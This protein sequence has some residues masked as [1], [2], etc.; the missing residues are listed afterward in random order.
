M[1]WF[2]GRGGREIRVRLVWCVGRIVVDAFHGRSCCR[3]CSYC[4]RCLMWNMKIW[5]Y[6]LFPYE[7]IAQKVKPLWLMWGTF[8]DIFNE[9]YLLR[10]TITLKFPWLPYT[11]LFFPKYQKGWRIL[12]VFCSNRIG[13][14]Y[15]QDFHLLYLLSRVS[16]LRTS[17]RIF[18]FFNYTSS[19]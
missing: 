7:N 14:F 18:S 8:R 3:L 15:Y 4:F 2:K 12:W 19:V 17:F 11:F 16:V 5:L 10:F 6:W 1:W 13:F 9:I